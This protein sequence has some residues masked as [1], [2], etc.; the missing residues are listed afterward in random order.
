MIIK[1]IKNMKARIKIGNDNRNQP[2]S[3]M[4]WEDLTGIKAGTSVEVLSE[5]SKTNTAVVSHNGRR[6]LVPKDALEIL[7]L[8]DAVENQVPAWQQRSSTF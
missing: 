2:G 3:T 1:G 8:D 5:C 6:R 7:V 4:R